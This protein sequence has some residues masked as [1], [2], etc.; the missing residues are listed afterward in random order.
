MPPRI[1]NRFALRN[2]HSALVSLDYSWFS[3][4][5]FPFN[6]DCNSSPDSLYFAIVVVVVHSVFFFSVSQ[7][8]TI[9]PVW[10]LNGKWDLFKIT[11]YVYVFVCTQCHCI[12]FVSAVTIIVE[13][14]MRASGTRVTYTPL[15]FCL[16]SS[17]LSLSLCFTLTPRDHFTPFS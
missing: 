9:V 12:Y 14:V 1:V 7:I 5:H 16:R 10:I 4:S 8:H 3:P 2:V 17:Y 6:T 15:F 13:L 11:F